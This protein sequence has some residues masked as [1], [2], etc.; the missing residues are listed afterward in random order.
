MDS[1]KLEE[2]K[3]G[4]VTLLDVLGWKGIWQRK[5]NPINDLINII[6]E[7]KIKNE[8]LR[9]SDVGRFKEVAM[10][11]Q[12]ISISDSIAI[13]SHGEINNTLELHAGLG[14]II[15]RSALKHKI[16]LRGATCAGKFSL[17]GNILIGPAIDEVAA[18]YETAEW[19]GIIQTPSAYLKCNTNIFGSKNLLTPYCVNTKSGNFYT[20]CVDWRWNGKVVILNEEELKEMFFEMQPITPDISKKI[21]NTLEFYK[22][23]NE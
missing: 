6:E 16:P 22:L 7:A 3:V 18:W 12:I 20:N 13:V 23:S 9:D 17:Q 15:L 5:E 1:I 11:T 2:M 4:S 8:A 14:R 19:I 21:M 10:N